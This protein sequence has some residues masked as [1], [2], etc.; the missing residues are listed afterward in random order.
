MSKV[1]PILR[2]ESDTKALTG[3]PDADLLAGLRRLDPEAF[4][5]LVDAYEKPLYRFFFY[6]HGDHDRALDDC[7]ETFVAVVKAIPKMQGGA[8]SLRAFV[9]GVARNV[10]RRGWREKRIIPAT[11]EE[12]YGV[13]DPGLSAFETTERRQRFEQAL[14]LIRQFDE[15]ERQVMLLRFVEELRLEEISTSL[16]LPVNTVKSH[17]RR[18]CARLRE[19]LDPEMNQ[20]KETK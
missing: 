3:Q 15:P 20:W 17:V 19:Q 13:V 11:D 6:S 1:Q 2:L 10:Q 14:A 16:D 12:L 7:S 18:C 8:D 5:R 9:F 4:A